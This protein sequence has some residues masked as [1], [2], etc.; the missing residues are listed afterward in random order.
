M[1]EAH[2]DNAFGSVAAVTEPSGR[3]LRHRRCTRRGVGPHRARRPRGYD[4]VG[5]G[6]TPEQPDVAVEELT[7]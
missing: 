1:T 2:F 4:G 6:G 3:G 7:V 5:E